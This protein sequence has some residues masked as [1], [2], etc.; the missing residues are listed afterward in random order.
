MTKGQR[1]MAVAM[2]RPI[3]ERVHRGK[4]SSRNG[5]LS[6]APSNRVAE[7][8]AVLQYAPDLAT[9]VLTGSSSRANGRWVLRCGIRSRR[10]GG[11]AIK[12]PP[13]DN[14]AASLSNASR[15]LVPPRAARGPGR[16]ESQDRARRG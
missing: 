14:L 16:G 15:K 10:S 4:K 8:R 3:P 6:D 7:A 1:A 13:A 2:L 5:N 9:N 12:G 11:A